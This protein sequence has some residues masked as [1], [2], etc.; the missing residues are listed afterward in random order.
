MADGGI[1]KVTKQQFSDGTTIDGDRIDDALEDV[2]DRINNVSVGDLKRRMVQN[3]YVMGFIPT[4]GVNH[5]ETADGFFPYANRFNN[6][7]G[8]TSFPFLYHIN[9]TLQNVEYRSVFSGQAGN[10]SVGDGG[11]LN[12]YRMKGYLPASPESPVTGADITGLDGCWIWDTSWYFTNPVIVTDLS[13][14]FHT[15]KT[16]GKYDNDFINASSGAA[17]DGNNLATSYINCTLSVD[18]PFQ[19]E[20]RRYNDKE[21][22]FQGFKADC[23]FMNCADESHSPA[24]DM[25]PALPTGGSEHGSNA[26]GGLCIRA[27][28]NSLNVPIKQNAR[29]RLDIEIP[30]F[31]FSTAVA[32]PWSDSSIKSRVPFSLQYYTVVVTV[33]EEVIA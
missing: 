27:L 31:N 2:K 22:A 7:T 24:N 5:G 11:A 4:N 21:I 18:N 15:T 14:I 17:P 29:V 23:Y 6:I 1:R 25:D 3:Q 9:S 8:Q 16:A 20:N 12:T 26:L 33:L 13:V 10:P 32:S 19:P 28:P 30:Q